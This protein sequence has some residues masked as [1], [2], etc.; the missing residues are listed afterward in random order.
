MIF[1]QISINEPKQC[2]EF[3]CVRLSVLVSILESKCSPPNPKLKRV[4]VQ[5][6]LQ[7]QFHTLKPL[8]TVP[9]QR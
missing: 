6:T 3:C 2:S 1:L 8:T 4:R 5:V 7:N 9:L